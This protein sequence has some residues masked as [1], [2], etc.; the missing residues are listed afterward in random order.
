MLVRCNQCMKIFHEDKIPISEDPLY[1]KD[2]EIC[3]KCFK[4][5]ALM[6]LPEMTT[7]QAR[8]E[9]I[10]L[11]KDDSDFANQYSEN[12]FNSWLEDY[13]IGLSD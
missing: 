1:M 12:D 13:Q 2:Q 10:N 4:G 8:D 6:D 11:R 7:Q 3:P 9:F 5:G